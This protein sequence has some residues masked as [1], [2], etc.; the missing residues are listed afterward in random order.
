VAGEPAEHVLVKV[1]NGYVMLRNTKG[2][3]LIFR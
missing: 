1:E 2:T 3:M